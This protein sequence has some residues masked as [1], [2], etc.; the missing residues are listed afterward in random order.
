MPGDE[1]RAQLRMGCLGNLGCVA[2]PLALGLAWLLLTDAA[3]GLAR[4]VVPAGSVDVEFIDVEDMFLEVAFIGGLALLI[5]LAVVDAAWSRSKLLGL[6]LT[7]PLTALVGWALHEQLF[8]RF[9]AVGA[10]G[11]DVRLVHR[12]PRPAVVVP[13][14][15]VRSAASE[16]VPGGAGEMTGWKYRLCLATT[17]GRVH[18]SEAAIDAGAVDRAVLIVRRERYAAAAASGRGAKQVDAMAR[19]ALVHLELGEAPRAADVAARAL[20]LA[21]RSGDELGVASASLAL[22]SVAR[23]ARR[24]DEAERHL[25]RCLA[26]RRAKLDA[27]HPDLY[28]A[29]DAYRALLETTG[30]HEEAAHLRAAQVPRTIGTESRRDHGRIWPGT[31]ATCGSSSPLP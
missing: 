9:V 23:N 10:R 14:S 15:S 16:K 6:L 12:W 26:N 13:G 5:G 22:G 25:R 17:D 28:D 20:A 1:E 19:L 29:I 31:T 30:R 18:L 8:A 4:Q 21:E 11:G 3:G 7:V 24:F 2:V 27:T